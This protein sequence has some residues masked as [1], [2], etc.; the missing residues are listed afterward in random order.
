MDWLTLLGALGVSNLLSIIVTWKLG[1]KRT[2]DANATLVEIEALVKVR[3]FYRDEIARLLKVNEELHATV[4][5]LRAELKEVK[6]ENYSH[7]DIP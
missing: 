1:G 6:G 7:A 4:N 5:E 3:E 2:S